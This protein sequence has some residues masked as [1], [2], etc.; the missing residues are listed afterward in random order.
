MNTKTRTLVGTGILTAIVIVLQTMASGIHIGQFS[1]TLVLIPIVVGAALYGIKAGA[2]LGFVFGL[3]TLGD[4][5]LFLGINAVGTVITCILK[6]TLAGVAAGFV[7]KM[8]ENKNRWVAVIAASLVCPIV[9]SGVFA[10]GCYVFM[11][12]G[13]QE[14]VSDGGTVTSLIFITFIGVN[15]LIEVGINIV[16]DPAILR[17]LNIVKK[18][19][20]KAEPQA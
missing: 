18:P 6:G 1:I 20:P 11:Y 9:N 3:I 8:L 4:A 2:W 19:A 10:L 15:F 14:M 5:A 17:I 13:L 12:K 7:Y 16:L